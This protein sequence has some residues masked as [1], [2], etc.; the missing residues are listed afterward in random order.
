MTSQ[1]RHKA[2]VSLKNLN[3]IL[4]HFINNSLR[5][6]H[7]VDGA[8]HLTH[9]H[10]DVVDLLLR[11]EFLAR[12]GVVLEVLLVGKLT[13]GAKFFYFLSAIRLPIHDVVGLFDAQRSTGVDERAD[14]VVISRSNNTILVPIGSSSLLRR[15]EAG[16]D[17]HG[18]SPQRQ[19]HG[20][21]TPIKDTTSSH[22]MNLA[23]RERGLCVLAKVHNRRDEDGG[24]NV[25]CVATTLSTLSTDDIDSSL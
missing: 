15:N 23:T 22:N 17:P 10:R 11:R 7:V 4:Y 1:L 6:L 25:A 19:A 20:E 5:R 12:L 16:A 24:S 2:S 3:R 9:E 14:S 18:R 13:L 8:G 21:T